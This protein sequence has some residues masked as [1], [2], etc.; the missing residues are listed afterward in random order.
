MSELAFN[1]EVDAWARALDIDVTTFA[2]SVA[3]DLTTKIIE[4]TP[5]LTGTAQNNWNVSDKAP[6]LTVREVGQTRPAASLGEPPYFIANNLPYI[7]PLENGHSKQAPSGM[8]AVSLA[9]MAAR[10]EATVEANA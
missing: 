2:K 10:I 6:D 3:L 9:E 1:L 7:V 8:V 5:V 4:R